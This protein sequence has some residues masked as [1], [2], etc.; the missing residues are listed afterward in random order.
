MTTPLNIYESTITFPGNVVNLIQ[1]RIESIDSELYVV[2]RILRETDPQA[3]VGIVAT[4]WQPDEDSIEIRGHNTPV[5]PTLSTYLIAVQAFIKD[6]NEERGLAKHTVLSKLIRSVLYRDA[7]L[8]VGLSALS[9]SMND[10]VERTQRWGIRT[11]RFLANE[12]D[13]DFLYLSTLEFWLE[14]ETT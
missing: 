8:R 9:V 12:I 3:S 11:Q 6:F 13:G 14:T 7:A 1:P 4:Q 5:E 10:S 2:R